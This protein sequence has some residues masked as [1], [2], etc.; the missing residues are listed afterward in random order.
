M[1]P[2]NNA[3]VIRRAIDLE[4]FL[5]D[6]LVKQGDNLKEVISSVVK[7]DIGFPLLTL[8]S[9]SDRLPSIWVAPQ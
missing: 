8:Y 5:D 3:T 6:V 4:A 7:P 2:L 9:F 1:A